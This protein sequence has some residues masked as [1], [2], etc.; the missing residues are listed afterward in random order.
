MWRWFQKVQIKLNGLNTVLFIF[1]IINMKR[2]SITHTFSLS[3]FEKVT[4]NLMQNLPLYMHWVK[5]WG[6][7]Y[8]IYYKWIV[9]L[10]SLCI[11]FSPCNKGK[12]F[13]LQ[14]FF[15]MKRFTF[16]MSAYICKWRTFIV[17]STFTIEYLRLVYVFE[18]YI[19]KN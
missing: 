19:K 2:D 11:F 6:F 12:V 15:K 8:A 7:I 5:D 9:N 14:Y 10:N 17:W 4:W 13:S 3:N 18:N 1:L 16:T